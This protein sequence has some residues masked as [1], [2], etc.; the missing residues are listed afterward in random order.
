MSFSALSNRKSPR[1]SV[2]NVPV[3]S[4]T[5]MGTFFS[6]K[7]PKK[8]RD[9]QRFSGCRKRSAAKGVR[10]LFFV[11]GTLSVTFRS[12]FLTLLSLFSSLFCQ[13]P[14]AGLLLRRGEIFCRKEKSHFCGE[15]QFWCPKKSCDFFTYRQSSE[16]PDVHK[17]VCSQNCGSPPAGKV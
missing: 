3:A 8:N 7:N 5:A 15:G 11:F 6:S 14:F 16:R 17:I 9:R 2:T 10:S 13:T 12:L 4:Q 1:F